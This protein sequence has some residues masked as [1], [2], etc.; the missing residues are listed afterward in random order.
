MGMDYTPVLE[1]F[2]PVG[3]PD[4]DTRDIRKQQ[5]T[6]FSKSG[7][8]ETDRDFAHAWRL[9]RAYLD[10]LPQQPGTPDENRKYTT[11][12][13]GLPPVIASYLQPLRHET[14]GNNSAFSQE[15]L[16]RLATVALPGLYIHLLTQS[17]DPWREALSGLE[18]S[19]SFT[20]QN[21]PQDSFELPYPAVFARNP[22]S[23]LSRIADS[24]TTVG[25][26]MSD[27]I[28]YK[29]L[30]EYIP[31]LNVTR[32][33]ASPLEFVAVDIQR[34]GTALTIASA[35]IGQLM[36]ITTKFVMV[37]AKR[38]HKGDDFSAEVDRYILK[39]PKGYAPSEHS[40]LAGNYF[41]APATMDLAPHTITLFP[42]GMLA[43]GG[44]AAA[45]GNAL[46]EHR[47]VLGIPLN[48]N[49]H[50][51][52]LFMGSYDAPL[53]FDGQGISIHAFAHDNNLLSHN[54]YIRPGLGDWGD[55]SIGS[56]KIVCTETLQQMA[57]TIKKARESVGLP[58]IHFTDLIRRYGLQLNGRDI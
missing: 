24:V 26:N 45:V 29:G 21:N 3:E 19:V 22:I 9:G 13:I 50:L 40:R 47:D 8:T 23:H 6:D 55:R 34:G 11:A 17:G 12:N 5:L 1:S 44:S 37:D 16:A 38:A 36:G 53:L 35:A 57:E 56:G 4:V 20:H 30:E 33:L 32:Q 54:G 28:V 10:P 27:A 58:F 39:Q 25:K 51:V 52:T 46:H 14:L 7:A 15:G 41:V 2:K 48:G 49:M 42:D 43:T 31:H 18:M